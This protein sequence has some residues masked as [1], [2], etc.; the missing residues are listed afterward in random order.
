MDDQLPKATVQSRYD[1]LLATQTH[2]SLERNEAL[3]GTDV[4]VTIER[5][6]SKTDSG[7]ATGRTRTNKLVHA[8]VD[9][10]NMGDTAVVRV[11]EAHAHY[12][13]GQPS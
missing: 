8:D 5:I 11:T 12:L 7:R 10:V 13:V 4:A 1:R 9:G 6:A 2:I 3:V